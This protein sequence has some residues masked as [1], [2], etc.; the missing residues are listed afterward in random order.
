MCNITFCGLDQISQL[1][2]VMSFGTESRFG[3]N[4]DILLPCC[5]GIDRIHRVK[6]DESAHHAQYGT[7]WQHTWLTVVKLRLRWNWTEI[8]RGYSTQVYLTY[9]DEIYNSEI[10]SYQSF[11]KVVP[12]AGNVARSWRACL[13]WARP[14]V[15]P[16]YKKL[17]GCHC[18][19]V[20]SVFFVCLPTSGWNVQ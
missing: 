17:R 13:A 4:K 15:Q 14:Q 3:L 10:S 11:L 12:W 2:G 7:L 19:S 9:C 5:S 16:Q 18:R 20:H 8:P 6:A 1:R